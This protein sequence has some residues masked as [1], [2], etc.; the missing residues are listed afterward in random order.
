[1]DILGLSGVSELSA[2]H[3]RAHISVNGRG[4][5]VELPQPTD[6]ALQL[7]LFSLSGRM[8]KAW[9]LQAGEQRYVLPLGQLSTSVYALQLDGTPQLSGSTLIR[10]GE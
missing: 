5:V 3:T 1:L 4:L 9:M 2:T 6:R 8:V 7:R 10:I